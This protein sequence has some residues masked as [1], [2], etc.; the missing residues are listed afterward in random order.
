MI[1]T[2]NAILPFAI[3]GMDLECL[4]LSEKVSQ[5]KK[6]TIWFHLYV[7]S[8]ENK[9]TNKNKTDQ[10]WLPEERGLGGLGEKR[11]RDWEV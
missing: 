6:N 1:K 5:R 8:K 7:E 3:A 4:T 11:W 10:Q 9:W 2:L